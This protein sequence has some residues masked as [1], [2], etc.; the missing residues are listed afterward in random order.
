MDLFNADFTRDT[1]DHSQDVA[2]SR[3]LEKIVGYVLSRQYAVILWVVN[4]EHD[5]CRG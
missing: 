2:A 4:P 1:E 5:S 3:V